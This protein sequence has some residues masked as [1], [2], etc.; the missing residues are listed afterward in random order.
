MPTTIDESLQIWITR[1]AE[2][3]DVAGRHVDAVDREARWPSEAID[4]LRRTGLLGAT[5]TPTVFAPVVRIIAEKCASTAMIYLMHVCGTQVIA[6]ASDFSRRE[7]ILK[8]I[9]GN[10]HLTTLAFSEKGSRSNFWAPVSRAVA[11]NGGLTVSAEKSFVTSASHADS[12]VVSTLSH[13]SAGPT[14]STMYFVERAAGGVMIG[15]AWRG[16]GLRG[17]DSSP[18]R[19]ENVKVTDGDRLS[20]DGAG[21]GVMLNPVLPWFQLGTAAVAVGI[22]NASAGSTRAHLLSTKLE[23][24]GE[25]LADLPN[26]R[27]RLARMQIVADAQSA[28]IRSVAEKMEAG[29]EDAML[30]VL[31]SKASAGEAVLEVT[32]LGMRAC[33]GA[34]FRGDVGVERQFRD[35]RAGAVMA[36]TTDALHEFIGKALLGIPLF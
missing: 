34:A 19:L 1:A 6:Q 16:M 5:L 14:E 25:S 33:G 24:A 9:A 2:V 11:A 26:L 10:R 15:G 35:A 28:F 4:A 20:G 23:H 36:P 29:G 30:A 27:A 17:N 12:Y 13:K 8:E 21:F 3:A 7:E 18:V 32:D 22:A 31:E